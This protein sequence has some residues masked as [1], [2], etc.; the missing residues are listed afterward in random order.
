MNM[1]EDL[2]VPLLVKLMLSI[3]I[4]AAVL[5]MGMTIMK[6]QH[7]GYKKYTFEVRN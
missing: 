1:S 4:R 2:K 6:Y 7:W 3:K 5:V